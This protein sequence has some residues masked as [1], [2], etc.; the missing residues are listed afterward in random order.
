MSLSLKF[1]IRQP[2]WPIPGWNVTWVRLP[3]WRLTP[4]AH[5]CCARLYMRMHI[6]KK[7][8]SEFGQ[9]SYKRLTSEQGQSSTE[10]QLGMSSALFPVLPRIAAE[11]ESSDATVSFHGLLDSEGQ[12]EAAYS[13]AVDSCE[14]ESYTGKHRSLVTAF[15]QPPS[16]HTCGSRKPSELGWSGIMFPQGAP[17]NLICSFPGP[18]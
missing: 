3:A 5:S 10:P 13:A 6:I 4:A 2:V 8:A 11:K 18:S 7:K 17:V 16:R 1:C 9:T 12:P 15:G 14:G